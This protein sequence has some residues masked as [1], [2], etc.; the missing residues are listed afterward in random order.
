MRVV[1]R[2]AGV[3]ADESLVEVAPVVLDLLRHLSPR[4]TP[5]VLTSWRLP[6]SSATSKALP[7]K[8][9]AAAAHMLWIMRP[10]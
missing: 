2:S 7:L 1:R 10:G 3:A 5:A 9:Y 8:G 6:L 4:P